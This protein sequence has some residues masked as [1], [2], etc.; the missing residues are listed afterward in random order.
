[1]SNTNRNLLDM[2]RDPSLSSAEEVVQALKSDPANG[3]MVTE[4]SALRRIHGLNKLEEEEKVLQLDSRVYFITTNFLW[5]MV[6]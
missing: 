6:L 3:L 4:V 2:L 1:V 5:M